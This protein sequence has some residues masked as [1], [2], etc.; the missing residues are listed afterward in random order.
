MSRRLGFDANIASRAVRVDLLR[1]PATVASENGGI[2]SLRK[3]K[4]IICGYS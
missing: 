3:M 2:I 1:L 4:M